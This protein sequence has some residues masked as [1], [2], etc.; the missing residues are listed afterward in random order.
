MED[1][2]LSGLTGVSQ[3]LSVVI[4]IIRHELLSLMEQKVGQTALKCLFKP[5]HC[6]EEDMWTYKGNASFPADMYTL[7]TKEQKLY[8]SWQSQKKAHT[9]TGQELLVTA[10]RCQW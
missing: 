7:T 10:R 3:D 9:N 4:H 6:K 8:S 2:H 1:S 5:V